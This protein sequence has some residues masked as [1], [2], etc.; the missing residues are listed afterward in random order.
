[1]QESGASVSFVEYTA[2]CG[3]E[4]EHLEWQS[5]LYFVTRILVLFGTKFRYSCK[6]RQDEEGQQYDEGCHSRVGAHFLSHNAQH[7]PKE[8]ETLDACILMRGDASSDTATMLPN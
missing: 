5:Y 6:R 8:T 4:S 7:P 3:T 2:R 1:M